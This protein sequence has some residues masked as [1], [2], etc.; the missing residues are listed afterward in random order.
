LAQGRIFPALTRMQEVSAVIAKEVALVAYDRK[1]A[2]RRK[3][4]DLLA[5]IKSLMYQPV[6]ENYT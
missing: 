1:L 4:S 3:P 5:Y 6:Y 2:R